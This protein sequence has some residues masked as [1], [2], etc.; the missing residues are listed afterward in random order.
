MSV[1]V[2]TFLSTRRPVPPTLYGEVS[3][4]VIVN[5]QAW[6]TLVAEPAG[7]VNYTNLT[8]EGALVNEQVFGT[9][10]LVALE[11]GSLAP[12]VLVN[13][14]G[15]AE[16]V[17]DPMLPDLVE[18][19]YGNT[20]GTG[21]RTSIISVSTNA[22]ISSGTVDNLV[23]GGFSNNA[24]DGFIWNAGQTER[25]VTFDFGTP[26]V[27]DEITWYM[28]HDDPQNRWCIEASADASTWRL[29]HPSTQFRGATPVFPMH[30]NTKGFRYWRFRQLLFETSASARH[31]ECEFRIGD[32]VGVE[33][34]FDWR[35]PFSVGDR[36]A[37]IAGTTSTFTSG[38]S[39]VRTNLYDGDYAN[40]DTDSWWSGTTPGA[41]AN[42]RFDFGSEVLVGGFQI[43]RASVPADDVGVW[44][45]QRSP[46]DSEWT[47]I[48]D[49]FAWVGH[50]L[51]V[52]RPHDVPCRYYRLL[53][54]SGG[55]ST[56]RLYEIHFLG[57]N[58]DY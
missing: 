42:I 7:I 11:Y 30:H 3:P 32:G 6:P 29:M 36:Q 4:L 34:Q 21:D 46:D 14:N 44:R 45:W 12:E 53:R 31:L 56:S 25:V 43:G 13:L 51:V 48:G 54:V 26:K 2:T 52:Y 1:I 41:G 9:P 58:P 37:I 47:T 57:P 22:T 55:W 8:I 17:L 10:S 35:A 20:G 23:D 18:T 39:S 38:G 27:I 49:D 15:F 5:A 16:L 24:S 50:N 40:N 28:T 33:P 19:D